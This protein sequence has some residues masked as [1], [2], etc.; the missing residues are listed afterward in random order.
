MTKT[1]SRI[2]DYQ[3][4]KHVCDEKIR[5][6]TIEHEPRT[7]QSLPTDFKDNDQ[8]PEKRNQVP[9]STMGSDKKCSR[10]KKRF[11]FIEKILKRNSA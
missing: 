9:R 8:G 7:V 1:E 4:I 5:Q 3:K 6:L 11:S 10:P 2:L